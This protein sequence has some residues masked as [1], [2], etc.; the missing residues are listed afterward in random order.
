MI[1]KNNHQGE[2]MPGLSHKTVILSTNQ[3][4]QTLCRNRRLCI[5]HNQMF[6]SKTLDRHNS[7]STSIYVSILLLLPSKIVI[8]IMF[9]LD[10]ITILSIDIWKSIFSK[11]LLEL[12]FGTFMDYYSVFAYCRDS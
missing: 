6:S 11:M 10:N 12:P 2:D 1:F 3:P 7:L 4:L 9:F 5:E 8:L